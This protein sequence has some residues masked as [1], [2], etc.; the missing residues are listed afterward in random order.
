MK[1][2]IISRVLKSRNCTD[3]PDSLAKKGYG[4]YKGWGIENEN[5]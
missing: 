2:D 3:D 4:D 5:Y 1:Q